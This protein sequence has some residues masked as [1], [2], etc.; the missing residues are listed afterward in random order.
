M[1]LEKKEA[2][3]KAKFDALSDEEKAALK[4]KEEK[5]VE[6]Q[7]QKD[8]KIQLDFE[9]QLEKAKALHI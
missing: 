3:R 4:V 7:K 5:K 2:E 9:R 6:I 8:A 1:A